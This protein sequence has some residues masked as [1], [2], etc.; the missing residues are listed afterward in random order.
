[1]LLEWCVYIYRSSKLT[2]H[3]THMRIW[4]RRYGDGPLYC[5]RSYRPG[6]SNIRYMVYNTRMDDGYIGKAFF[7]VPMPLPCPCYKA[8]HV[9]K[10]THFVITQDQWYIPFTR[11]F[12]KIHSCF[13]R[14]GQTDSWTHS[15][16]FH[17]YYFFGGKLC[18][19]FLFFFWFRFFFVFIYWRFNVYNLNRFLFDCAVHSVAS[20]LPNAVWQIYRWA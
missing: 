11:H 17:L 7:Q 2:R 16:G 3:H 6:R 1:M 20:L 4:L 18:D 19:S 10:I 14:I 9:I 13:R 15:N 5:D 12:L 8:P